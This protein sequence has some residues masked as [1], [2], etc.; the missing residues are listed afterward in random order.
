MIQEESLIGINDLKKH[1]RLPE[2]DEFDEQLKLSLYASVEWCENYS[3]RK[4]AD[5]AETG[6]PYQ[7]KA[8]ILMKAAFLF[9]NPSDS[10]D[11]RV[12]AAQH[13]ADPLIWEKSGT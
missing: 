2:T 9:E 12:T 4:L 13:L 10:V 11:E 5:F 8:A 7:L 3:G 6:L 1:L